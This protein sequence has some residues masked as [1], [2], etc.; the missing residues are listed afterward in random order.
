MLTKPIITRIEKGSRLMIII[1]IIR[2]IMS[3]IMIMTS[4]TT[5]I[6]I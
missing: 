2:M 5:V 3:M 6:I 4:I 1:Y